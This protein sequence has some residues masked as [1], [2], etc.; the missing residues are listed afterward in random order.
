MRRKHKI[1][2]ILFVVLASSG[3]AIAAERGDKFDSYR[4]MHADTQYG[5]LFFNEG[6]IRL[7]DSRSR[8]RFVKI[9]GAGELSLPSQEGYCFVFNHYGSSSGTGVNQKYRLKISKVFADGRNKEEKLVGD[10]APTDNVVSSRLPDWCIAGL[11]NVSKVSLE[12]S[13]DDGYFD[14]TISMSIK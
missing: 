6:S 8:K 4:D 5:S 13:S 10:Y 1:V 14:R 9:T 12:F 3:D 11:L 2:C 7:L